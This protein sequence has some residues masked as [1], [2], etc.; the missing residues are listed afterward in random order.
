MAQPTRNR[1]RSYSVSQIDDIDELNQPCDG[2]FCSESI[3]RLSITIS[4]YNHLPDQS[5]SVE[6]LPENQKLQIPAA[7]GMS[8]TPTNSS[9]CGVTNHTLYYS[10]TFWKLASMSYTEIASLVKTTTN[11]EAI[12]E[13]IDGLEMVTPVPERPSRWETTEADSDETFGKLSRILRFNCDIRD[14]GYLLTEDATVTD[15]AWSENVENVPHS[16]LQNKLKPYTLQM[17]AALNHGPVGNYP[18]GAWVRA[19]GLGFGI[20]PD[21][22]SAYKVESVY[23]TEMPSTDD[24]T[25]VLAFQHSYGETLANLCLNI[26]AVFGLLHLSKD[27]TYVRGDDYMNRIGKSYL[28][29]LEIPDTSKKLLGLMMAKHKECLLRVAPHPFGLAQTYW[30]AKVMYMHEL[31]MPSLALR[32]HHATPPPVQRIMVV[33]EAAREWENI[34]EASD[35]LEMFKDKLPRLKAQEVAIKEAPPRYSDLYRLYGCEEKM[36]ISGEVRDDLIAFMPATYGYA[37][38][39]HMLARTVRRRMV[40][41]WLAVSRVSNVI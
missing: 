22:G 18:L 14:F 32:F 6:Y 11:G 2:D 5:V 19:Y 33:C 10:T 25:A 12:R 38:W 30:L 40:S 28:E 41:L 34:P 9:L 8:L 29:A 23:T 1:E 13:V 26:L 37:I 39:L 3:Y 7:M 16:R 31:L 17:I 24:Q 20:Y 21:R 4:K 35:V 36:E 15:S 27:K